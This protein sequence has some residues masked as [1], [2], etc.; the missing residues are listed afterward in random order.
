MVPRSE[1]EKGRLIRKAACDSTRK[2]LSFLTVFLD[3]RSLHLA[4]AQF[5]FWG[6][7]SFDSHP[8]INQIIRTATTHPS[9]NEGPLN[10]SMQLPP[11]P[12]KHRRHCNQGGS[13]IRYPSPPCA[14]S[15]FDF[16]FFERR[17]PLRFTFRNR[18]RFP[19]LVCSP[20]LCLPHLFSLSF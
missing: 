6:F 9:I 4:H 10:H 11:P 13:A 18:R 2:R 3:T 14:G 19:L 12:S 20:Q 8:S 15:L 17:L 16:P 7:A 1:R 5:V